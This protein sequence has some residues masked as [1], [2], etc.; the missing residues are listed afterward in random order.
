MNIASVKSG[1]VVGVDIRGRRF[2]AY[3][4]E[5]IK[6]KG[7]QS[8]LKI[9][10]AEPNNSYYTCKANQVTAHYKKMQRKTAKRTTSNGETLQAL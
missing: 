3:V 5:I 6:E 10:P 1:D 8:H 2:L 7:K 4:D 9:T